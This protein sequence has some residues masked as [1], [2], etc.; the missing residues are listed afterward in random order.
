MRHFRILFPDRRQDPGKLVVSVK[1]TGLSGQQLYD[2]LLKE[3]HLQLEMATST[4]V[5]AMFTIGDSKEG[6]DRLTEA[7]EEMDESLSN[8]SAERSK[9]DFADNLLQLERRVPLKEAWDG[10]KQWCPL[11][12]CEGRVVSEFVNLYPPGVPMAVPGEL[13]N[14][15]LIR[16]IKD[17]LENGLNVQGIKQY[18]ATTYLSVIR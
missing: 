11:S 9:V 13:I 4:Y 2:M 16:W 7:L 10:E 14:D 8:E 3:Y 5:L 18:D 17:C 1:K 15:A 12:E 6:F